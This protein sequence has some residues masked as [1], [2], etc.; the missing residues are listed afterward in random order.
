MSGA[1]AIIE[2]ALELYFAGIQCEVWEKLLP[3]GWIKKL[4]LKG[5]LIL[6]ENIK[7]RKTLEN[8]R[9]ED[10]TQE[11]LKAKGWKKV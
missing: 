9:P 2:R 8:Y 6:Y 7:C 1:N 4:V 11:S 3:S 10:Y 5:D